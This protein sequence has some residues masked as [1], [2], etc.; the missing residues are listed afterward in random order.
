MTTLG[1]L[2]AQVQ[3]ELNQFTTNRERSGTFKGWVLDGAASRVGVKLAD[4]QLASTM[5]NMLVELASGEIVHVSSFDANSSDGSATCP[6][7]FRG[8]LGTPRNDVVATDTRVSINPVWPKY[9]V[10]LKLVEGIQAIAEDVFPVREVSFPEEP[11]RSNYEMPGD[12]EAILKVVIRELGP[13][14]EDHKVGGW[15]LDTLNPDGK[16]YMRI[17]PTGRGGRTIYVTYRAY[18]TAPA[19]TDLAATWDSTGLPVSAVDLPKLFALSSLVLSADAAKTQAA[20][21]EQTE[22]NRLVQAGS[23][24]ATSRRY[25]QLF[26]RRLLEEIRKLRAKFPPRIHRQVYG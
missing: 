1:D 12:A 5:R 14:Q 4:V 19:P 6:P 13:S 22:R 11:L 3:G 26:E 18:A 16:R 9:H 24:G 20:S 25:E 10:A 8:Q 17:T 15:L 7:W 23:A 2:I 21:V